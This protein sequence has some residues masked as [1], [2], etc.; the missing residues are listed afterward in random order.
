MTFLVTGCGRSGTLY[1]AK[2]LRLA[3]MDVGHERMG[4]DGA[5]SSCWCAPE[6]PYPSFHQP[7]PRPDFDIVLHQVREPLATIGS[8]TTGGREGWQF[9]A[10]WVNLDL[11][12]HPI[13]RAAYYWFAWNALAEAQAAYTYR[14]ENLREEWP[15]LMALLGFDAPYAVCEAVP[16]DTNSREHV[17]VSWGDLHEHAPEMVE[18]VALMAQR[19]GY[20]GGP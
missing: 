8:L 18:R 17:R 3:G 14:I 6:P 11:G 20:G 10:R 13:K 9:N 5:V 19:Y 1:I 2:C 7:G 15:V 16:K 4:E 12:W